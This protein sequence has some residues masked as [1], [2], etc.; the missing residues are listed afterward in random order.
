MWIGPAPTCD[1]EPLYV[2]VSALL[3]KRLT[4]IGRFAARLIEALNKFV[5]IRLVTTIQEELARSIKLSTSLLCGQE[6]RLRKAEL[7]S[8]DGD[9]ALWVREL[10]RRPRRR[11][12]L[13]ESSRH[14]GMYTML[15]ANG[16]L[17]CN[18]VYSTFRRTATVSNTWGVTGGSGLYTYQ[19]TE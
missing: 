15:E 17:D 13:E 10:L 14:P 11:H 6:I 3:N 2:E 9:V 1:H 18:Y 8:A 12:D 4:G 7:D 16:D 19:E 5:P